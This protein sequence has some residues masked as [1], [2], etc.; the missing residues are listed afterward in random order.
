MDTD[1]SWAIQSYPVS[2]D[3]T[4]MFKLEAAG[5]S[6]WNKEQKMVQTERD[7]GKKK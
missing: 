4:V 7:I 6:L 2:E 3:E 5:N 1:P